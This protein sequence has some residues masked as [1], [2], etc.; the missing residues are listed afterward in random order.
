MW[1]LPWGYFNPFAF[2]IEIKT[3]LKPGLN[4]L[5]QHSTHKNTLLM[6]KVALV[7]IFQKSIFYNQ[8]IKVKEAENWYVLLVTRIDRFIIKTIILKAI[9][10]RHLNLCWIV[11]K[12]YHVHENS[13]FLLGQKNFKFK[14]GVRLYWLTF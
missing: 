8:S 5:L 7:F 14:V 9:S 3:A 10:K 4:N 11:F 13:N 6:K 12:Y 1:L 2:Q